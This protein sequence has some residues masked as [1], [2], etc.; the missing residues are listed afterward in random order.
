MIANISK[1]VA[2]IDPTKRVVEIDMIRGFALLGVLLINIRHFGSSSEIWDSG[3]DRFIDWFQTFFFERK[4]Y[5]FL[6][7]IHFQIFEWS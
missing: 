3:I 6:Q 4:K 1:Q 2:P 7:Q 5:F